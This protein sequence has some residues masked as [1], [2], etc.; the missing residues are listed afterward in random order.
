VDV[1]LMTMGGVLIPL[2]FYI[3]AEYPGLQ[4]HATVAIFVGL[5]AWLGAYYIV[6]KK[7]KREKI[8][9][10]E[11]RDD[12]IELLSEIRNESKEL[13]NLKTTKSK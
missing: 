2:G 7:E 11:D 12:F 3:L 4:N 5:A 9:R 1:L 8:E 10:Q 6:R 13:K